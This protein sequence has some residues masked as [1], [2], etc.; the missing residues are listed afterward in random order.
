MSAGDPFGGRHYNTYPL[1]PEHYKYY[2]QT[3]QRGQIIG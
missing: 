3:R 2:N 1:P